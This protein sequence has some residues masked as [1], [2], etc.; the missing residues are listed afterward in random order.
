MVFWVATCVNVGEYKCL[1]GMCQLH[2]QVQSERVTC[3]KVYMG[4]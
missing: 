2:L 3:G 1:K 4:M